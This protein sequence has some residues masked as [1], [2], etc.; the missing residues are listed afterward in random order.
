MASDRSIFRLI[1]R[2]DHDNILANA[3]RLL[4]QRIN[5]VRNMQNNNA[6]PGEPAKPRI[7]FVNMHMSGGTHE[8]PPGE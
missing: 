4:M 2:D 6:E 5:D 8:G 7:L 3:T 1:R